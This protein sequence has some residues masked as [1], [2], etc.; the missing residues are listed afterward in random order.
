MRHES[1]PAP[2]PDIVLLNPNRYPDVDPSALR[3]WLARLLAELAA[4]VNGVAVRFVGDRAMRALNSRYRG[5]DR[6]TDV[7]SFPGEE[8]PEGTHLGDIAISVPQARRQ[9]NE[10]GHSVQRELRCLL[11]HGVLHC[12]GHDHETDGG[13]MNG[14]ELELRERWVD[15]GRGNA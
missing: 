4:G 13:A 3:P 6:T 9:A 15:R 7:L 14:L 2:E 1:P 10:L 8:T 12:L 11:L 5:S